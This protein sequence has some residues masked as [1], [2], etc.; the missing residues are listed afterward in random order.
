MTSGSEPIVQGQEPESMN[1]NDNNGQPP[2][3]RVNPGGLGTAA[4]SVRPVQSVQPA[5]SEQPT[6]SEQFEQAGFRPFVPCLHQIMGCRCHGVEAVCK[7]TMK[8]TMH[9]I[10]NRKSNA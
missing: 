5:Q 1:L 3:S 7:K 8:P 6:Y 10:L 9:P 4:R 2:N